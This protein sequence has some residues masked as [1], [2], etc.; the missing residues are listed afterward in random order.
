M[1]GMRVNAGRAETTVEAEGKL[2]G[3][4]ACASE[5]GALV[6]PVSQRFR[7]E[8]I[9]SPWEKLARRLPLVA[10]K[11]LPVVVAELRQAG[12]TPTVGVTIVPSATFFCTHGISV[13]ARVGMTVRRTRPAH[14]LDSG[15]GVVGV[16]RI[17][18]IHRTI[19][20]AHTDAFVSCP[21]RAA[22]FGTA[23]VQLVNL[24]LAFQRF[25]VGIDERAPLVKHLSWLVDMM[26]NCC[27]TAP[28]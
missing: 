26:P 8:M 15:C 19:S 3:R 7:L 10:L 9:E 13:G 22:F 2:V 1:V 23:D 25:A 6:R 11:H 24:H 27:E 4:L 20:T 17:M 5:H 12:R 18:A 16:L 14:L 21:T 28:R